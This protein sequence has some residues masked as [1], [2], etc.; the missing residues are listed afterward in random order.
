VSRRALRPAPR[1]PWRTDMPAHERAPLLDPVP[2][3]QRPPPPEPRAVP[4]RRRREAPTPLRRPPGPVGNGGG[5]VHR[6]PRWRRAILAP[7]P[8][9]DRLRARRRALP[10][11]PRARP[12]S[13]KT[14]VLHAAPQAGKSFPG[15]VTL[16]DRAHRLPRRLPALGVFNP[17]AAAGRNAPLRQPDRRP[18]QV[19]I[20]SRPVP[21]AS[22]KRGV[23]VT[24]RDQPDLPA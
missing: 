6:V 18:R 10:H 12:P 23:K 4:E 5:L 7:R 16:S 22:L 3:L 9:L 17:G 2:T 11:K 13:L 20:A 14:V 21:K 15:A 19:G 1:I 24:I 8:P